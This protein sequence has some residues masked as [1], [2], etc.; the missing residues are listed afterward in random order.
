V[1]KPQLLTCDG[2]DQ[3][4]LFPSTLLRGISI[5]QKATCNVAQ[6]T[7]YMTQHKEQFKVVRGWLHTSSL[8]EALELEAL[9]KQ[10]KDEKVSIGT[11]CYENLIGVSLVHVDHMPKHSPSGSKW[12]LPAD[13]VRDPAFISKMTTYE[14]LHLLKPQIAFFLYIKDFNAYTLLCEKSH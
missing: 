14:Q 1:I 13:L 8:E 4:I 7:E 10:M 2:N 12:V 6:V 11:R 5:Y 9:A 3:I